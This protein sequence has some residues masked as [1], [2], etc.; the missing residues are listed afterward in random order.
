MGFPLRRRRRLLVAVRFTNRVSEVWAPGS[1]SSTTE[2]VSPVGPPRVHRSSVFCGIMGVSTEHSS[3][4]EVICVINEWFLL[5]TSSWGGAYGVV[6]SCD[7][8]LHVSERIFIQLR[9]WAG[10]GNRRAW[11]CCFSALLLVKCQLSGDASSNRGSIVLRVEWHRRGSISG[12]VVCLWLVDCTKMLWSAAVTER[13]STPLQKCTKLCLSATK[14]L[15]TSAVL[16]GTT[17]NSS[18][19]SGGFMWEGAGRV[20]GSVRSAEGAG[21]LDGVMSVFATVRIWSP[22]GFC[23]R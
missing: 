22:V 19:D 6:P 1:G 17:D 7:W 20:P 18:T 4:I 14:V 21:P 13:V 11:R 10:H 5:I 3:I 12:S 16:P 23:H 9:T 15:L 8:L 2:A